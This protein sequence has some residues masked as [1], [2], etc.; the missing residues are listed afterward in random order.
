MSFNLAY[1][2]ITIYSL[3]RVSLSLMQDHEAQYSS[4]SF[5]L[6]RVLICLC[7]NFVSFWS[8]YTYVLGLYQII[9]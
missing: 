5:A 3:K 2:T 4:V 9:A 6:W 8:C 7:H 1:L